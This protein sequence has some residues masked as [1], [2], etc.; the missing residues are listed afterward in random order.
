MGKITREMRAAL[1]SHDQDVV[2]M[3]DELCSRRGRLEKLPYDEYADWLSFCAHA[4]FAFGSSWSRH[5]TEDYYDKSEAVVEGVFQKIVDLEGL[6]TEREIE[7]VVSTAINRYYNTDEAP[8]HD[9]SDLAS[10]E[11]HR[12]AHHRDFQRD[13]QKA[14]AAWAHEPT[15]TETK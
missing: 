10:Y 7:E 2:I 6:P 5:T 1:W 12:R 15:A 4:A 3:T 13:L 14:V 11:K 8:H 9:A